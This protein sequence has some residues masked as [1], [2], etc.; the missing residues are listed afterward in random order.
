MK[1]NLF[2]VDGSNSTGMVGQFSMG[3]E[4]SFH[5]PYLYNYFGA[6]WK[7]QK[8]TRFL[9]DVWFKD[10]IFGIP[11]DEDGGGMT[12]FVVFTSIG[13]YPVTPGLPFYDITSPVFEE[14]TI[15]L[16]NGKTFT[17]LGKGASR[18]KKYI[19]KAFINGKEITS[20]FIMH[21]QIMAGGTL[22]LILDELPNK[23]WGKNA[24]IPYN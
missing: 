9:L 20:P 24:K 19:Q 11:G 21:E 12:A 18:T 10:N 1:K 7:T 17:V 16:T 14:T 22:E 3:N 13:L 2:Y 6:P 4:P 5:I 15:N 23:D 8:R